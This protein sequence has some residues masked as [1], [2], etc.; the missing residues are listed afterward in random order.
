[1]ANYPAS[2]VASLISSNYN[3]VNA[4]GLTPVVK[5]IVV[6][7]REIRAQES[8]FILLYNMPAIEKKQGGD[9]NF[10]Y[11]SHPVSIDIRVGRVAAGLSDDA[12]A[13][14]DHA[15]NVKEEVRRVINLKRK[16]PGSNYDELRYERE[17]D[18]SDRMRLLFRW[19]LEAELVRYNESLP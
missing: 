8:D 10:A 18:L 2:V 16:T 11:V 15:T 3:S 17:Q 9:W 6:A 1:M 7:D 19:V 5:A 13:I 12:Q 14:L 4:D